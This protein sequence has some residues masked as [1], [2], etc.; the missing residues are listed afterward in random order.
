ML[1]LYPLFLVCYKFCVET[2]REI[3]VFR[4]WRNPVGRGWFAGVPTQH[5]KHIPTQRQLHVADKDK[6]QQGLICWHLIGKCLI[7]LS[8]WHFGEKAVS[9]GLE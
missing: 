7:R 8:V 9:W 6:L 1:P 4:M 5:I 3:V 2:Y